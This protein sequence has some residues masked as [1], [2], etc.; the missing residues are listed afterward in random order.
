MSGNGILDPKG[1]PI[2][3][4]KPRLRVEKIF[5]EPLKMTDT[6]GEAELLPQ[7]DITLVE[8]YKI[9]LLMLWIIACPPIPMADPETQGKTPL[10]RALQWRQYIADEELGRHFAFR[11]RADQHTEGSA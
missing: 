7:E 9:N 5:V 11:M 1:V 4:Q 2:I 6:D 10:L 3:G 8:L